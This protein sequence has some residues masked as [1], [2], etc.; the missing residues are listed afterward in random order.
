MLR[1]GPVGTRLRNIARIAVL[2]GG[3]LGDLLL[4]EPAIRSLAD[5]YPDAEIVLLGTPAHRELLTGR[6]SPVQE[7]RVLPVVHG[8]YEPK[9]AP[10]DAL[11]LKLFFRD[12]SFDLA[13]QLNGGGRWSNPF[14]RRL[15]AVWTAGSRTPDAAELNRW[16]PFHH[17][18][19]ETLR[20]L[21][22]VGLV[23]AKPTAIEPQVALASKDL[24]EAGPAL[25]GLPRPVLTVHPGASDPRRRWPASRFVDVISAVADQASVVIVG[26]DMEAE[27]VDLARDR[28]I[29]VRS[30]VGKLSLSG[31]LGV[32][33]LSQIVLAN[34]SGPRH[35]AQAVGT[36]TVSVYWLGNMINASPFGRAL[37]RTHISWTTQ[38]P[39]CGAVCTRMDLP[40]CEHDVSFVAD[41]PV[42]DV[43]ADVNELLGEPARGSLAARM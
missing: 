35:L 9:G 7:V 29:A 15:G 37:H 13:V 21:E 11:E 6:P 41:V 12:Q 34:D 28:G 18:Q 42:D 27:V 22:V 23:G 2:R 24:A 32:L 39:V 19:H 4:A 3:G 30:L 25:A 1:I 10:E 33:R 5:T 8:V 36:P 31:L 14:L 38:C 17:H 20:A 26:S 40:R 43:L 16:L